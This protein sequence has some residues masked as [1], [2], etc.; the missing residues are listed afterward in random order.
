MQWDTG[1]LKK[2]SKR[3]IHQGGNSKCAKY[4]EAAEALNEI[5]TKKNE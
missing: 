1:K 5:G 3:K 2:T 4:S